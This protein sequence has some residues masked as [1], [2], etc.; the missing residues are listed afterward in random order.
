MSRS[1]DSTDGSAAMPNSSTGPESDA[2]DSAQP[3]GDSTSRS[4]SVS[5]PWIRRGRMEDVPALLA[6]WDKAGENAGRPGD[7]AELI[8]NLLLWDPDSII[9]AESDGGIV[10]T[11][12]AGWD[13]WRAHMYRL[14]VDPDSRGRGIGRSLTRAAEERLKSLG[15]VRFDA[16]VLSGNLGGEA[17]WEAMGYR[18]QND[19]TRWIRF[20]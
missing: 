3:V 2:S 9:I 1:H 8:E 10:G 11:V 20:A 12:I 7:D 13:S 16:M 15:A 5:E 17:A 14:A 6:F 18:P 19:W 4:G